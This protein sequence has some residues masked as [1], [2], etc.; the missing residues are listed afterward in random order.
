ML[1]S[2]ASA[3]VCLAGGLSELT[4]S[5]LSGPFTVVGD[6]IG[7]QLDGGSV[8]APGA[9]LTFNSANHT[10]TNVS[11][12]WLVTGGG[13]LTAVYTLEPG[14]PALSKRLHLSMPAQSTVRQ[15]D[16]LGQLGLNVTCASSAPWATDY[17]EAEALNRAAAF[18]RCSTK[19][20]L[21]ISVANPFGQLK[22]AA[23]GTQISA[24]YGEVGVSASA[25]VSDH[26][27]FAPYTWSADG[28]WIRPQT[29]G[30]V[31]HSATP[32]AML[33]TAERDAFVATVESQL[34]RSPDDGLRTVKVNVAWDENDY[35]IDIATA[36]GRAEYK[37]I[38]DRNAELNVSHIVFAREHRARCRL[39]YHQSRLINA[40]APAFYQRLNALFR[41][42]TAANSDLQNGDF[43]D[44]DGNSRM[45]TG[46]EEVLWWGFGVG[47]RNG[48]WSSRSDGI[49]SSKIK[50]DVPASLMEILDYARQ[51]SVKLMPYVYPVIVGYTPETELGAIGPVGV[52]SADDCGAA[53]WLYPSRNPHV[54]R[55][56]CHSDLGSPEYQ[57]WLIKA[58]SSFHTTFE[59]YHGGYA[60]DGVF[61][62][63][64]KNHT[65]YAQWRGW[66]NVLEALRKLHPDLVIDNRLSAHAL[67][68][69]HMLAGSYDEPIAGDE[70]PETYGIPVPSYVYA[71][72]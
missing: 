18:H 36:E 25:F 66:A 42:S 17:G 50:A 72:C 29:L 63:E 56:T 54:K 44:G 15:V 67:G 39:S 32:P 48:T 59:Q 71:V 24:G 35:Q 22:S 69:W 7:L 4:S 62:G 58:L 43:F 57:A 64:A 45:D 65:L 33:N 9:G 38:I 1:D 3:N 37:R 70:N 12:T 40:L 26:V 27:L 47:V 34:L 8:L 6:S 61:L 30:G 2:P 11:F 46:W 20:G 13:V 14:W 60:F 51:K 16:L 5:N 68:P 41:R 49:K 21:M 19:D 31:D 10:A 55:L 28:G 53:P 52:G 23:V